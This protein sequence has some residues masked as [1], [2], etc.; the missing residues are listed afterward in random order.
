MNDIINWENLLKFSSE[1]QNKTP[2]HYGFVK[3][4][5][6]QK[7]YQKLLSEYPKLDSFRNG[8]DMSK[9][10]L[11]RDWNEPSDSMEPLK[12][13]KN[14]IF[15]NSW[16]DFKTYAESDE[17]LEQMTIFSGV[18]VNRLKFFRFIGYR[19]GGFQLPHV[20]KVGPNTLILFFYFSPDWKDG[21]A[22]GTYFASELDESKIIFEPYDLDNSMAIFHDSPNAI[23]GTR[24]IT[25]NKERKAVQ[26]QLEL[27]TENGGW[28]GGN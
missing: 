27:W 15:S 17:F 7:F 3:Q 5:F 22:G 25:N 9:T 19:N 28:S 14:N 11:F 10:Q 23:H 4:I 24:M 12:K 26:L 6:N 16:N 1:F 2:F 8:N 13:G 21:E 18:K 20:H